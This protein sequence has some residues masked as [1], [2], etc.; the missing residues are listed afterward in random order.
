MQK[1]F[2]LVFSIRAFTPTHSSSILHFLELVLLK[3]PN[4]NGVGTLSVRWVLFFFLLLVWSTCTTDKLGMFLVQRV[5]SRCCASSFCVHS[6]L[7]V[8]SIA[9]HSTKSRYPLITFFF[10]SNVHLSAKKKFPLH[11]TVVLFGGEKFQ[12]HQSQDVHKVKDYCLQI[13]RQSQSYIG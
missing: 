1:F 13:T 6:S 7:L 8:I 9:Q 5:G 10:F 3:M 2:L 11:F 12:I 4:K